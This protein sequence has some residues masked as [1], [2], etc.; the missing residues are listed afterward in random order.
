V[1]RYRVRMGNTTNGRIGYWLV[2]SSLN[3]FEDAF[4]PGSV[5]LA[6]QSVVHGPAALAPAGRLLAVLIPEC[7]LSGEHL[8]ARIPALSV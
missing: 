3:E 8:L 5:P 4:T 1:G 2:L 7:A 6:T